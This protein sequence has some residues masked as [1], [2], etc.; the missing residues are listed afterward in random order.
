MKTYIFQLCLTAKSH[1]KWH[2]TEYSSPT[3][4][5]AIFITNATYMDTYESSGFPP[6]SVRL[7]YCGNAACSPRWSHAMSI[8]PIGLKVP[9]LYGFTCPH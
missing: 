5:A 1:R 3:Y 9:G 7:H 8:C 6:S 2:G 4:E